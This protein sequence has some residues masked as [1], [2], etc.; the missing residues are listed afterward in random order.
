MKFFES[1]AQ[2]AAPAA[3]VWRTLVDAPAWSTW[4]SGVD[5]VDGVVALGNKITIRSAAAP[6]RTFP[7]KVTEFSA[8]RRL[9][10]T[11]GMPLG[12]FRGVRTYSL[13][14]SGGLTDFRMR[15]EYTGPLAGLIGRSI[16]DLTGSFEK[17]ARGLKLRV[18]TSRT[19]SA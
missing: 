10:F 2:I 4:D 12:L 1:H 16:P 15:E 17:F 5:G 9:V 8:P 14:E 7:V 13:S 3:D 11:G 18:E 6:G 19:T